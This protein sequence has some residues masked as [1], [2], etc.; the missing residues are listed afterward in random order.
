MRSAGDAV[1][2]WRGG[3]LR[4]DA[5]RGGRRRHDQGGHREQRQ[6]RPAFTPALKTPEGVAQYNLL[7]EA[8]ESAAASSRKVFGVL[9]LA[10]LGLSAVATFFLP[11]SPILTAGAIVG[12]L[13]FTLWALLWGPGMLNVSEYYT[14]PGSRDADG[15]HRCIS[16][17]HRGI[18]RKGEYRSNTVEAH[19]SKCG[20][21]FWNESK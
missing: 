1:T 16:C 18:Y 6:P 17:G 12:F 20:F 11:G 14:V 9:A 19:C 15:E 7:V 3:A 10:C 13:V 8:R 21:H 4:R 2:R 5:Q